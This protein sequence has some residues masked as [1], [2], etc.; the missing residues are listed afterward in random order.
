[1]ELTN[2]Q[3][4]GL[5]IAL[6]RYSKGERYTVIAGYAGTGKSTLVRF[7]ISELKGR[8]NI[9]DGD[10]VFSAFTGK[11]CTVLQKMGNKNVETL[12][13]LLYNHVLMPDGKYARMRRAK[14]EYSIVIVD[15]CS[16]IP[17]EMVDL[18]L[19]H[20]AYI[21]FCG[22][23]FQL[24]P[25]K[26][27]DGNTLLDSPHI[28]LDEIM[29]QA[30]D[31]EIIQLSMKIRNR[32][33]INYFKGNEV[34]IIPKSEVTNGH[35][36]WADIIICATN[37][38]KNTFNKQMR[39]LLD[40]TG[41][42]ADG[43]KVICSHNY[44]DVVDENENALVNGTIGYV[45][46]PMRAVKNYPSFLY[47][48]QI[49]NIITVDFE[50]EDGNDFGEIE[51]DELRVQTGQST[52][53]GQEKYKIGRSKKYKDSMP[54]EFDYGY[55]ITCHKSQGSEWEKVLIIEETFPFAE[56]DHARWLYTAVTRSS[57][58]VVLV[59]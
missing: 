32:E 43:D 5:K 33:P 46:A 42:L 56:E 38:T 8:Y 55:A 11:A 24:P 44:W 50:S 51:L 21:I 53:T 13:K 16:M 37:K 28:F 59:R 30:A 52:L 19:A 14:I 7:I 20:R 9:T 47:P 1:M 23:P 18:L 34:Q 15:E 2:K 31:S 40:K 25:V 29:R 41:I 54:Y 49:L 4:E 6:D 36:T 27:D 48:N 17:K 35:L 57:G 45:R 3:Q 58:K 10:I 39:F 12:H 26:A 22:D